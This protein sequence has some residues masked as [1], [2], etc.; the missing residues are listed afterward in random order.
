[1]TVLALLTALVLAAVGALHVVWMFS[2][3]PL[4]TREE[5]ASRVVGVPADRLPS[6]GLTAVPALLLALAAYLVVGRADLVAVPGPEWPAVVGTAGVAAVLLLRGVG[7]LVASA[8]KKTEFARL[9]LRIYSP[10]CIAL[11]AATAS[12]AFLA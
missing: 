1:M 8:G 6:P 10:L 9:D 3:W 11:S 12:V 2:P 4:R 7:G 5:F